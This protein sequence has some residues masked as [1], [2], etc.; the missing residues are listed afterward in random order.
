MKKIIKKEKGVTMVALVITVIILLILTNM[1]IYNATDSAQIKSLTS[2]YND[3]ELL[4]EKV[5]EYYNEYGKI[6]ANIEY[7]NIDHLGGILNA[8]EKET[9]S[10][11][12][13]IDLQTLQGL[14]LNYGNEYEEVKNRDM[15]TQI[16]TLLMK[17]H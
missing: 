7:T 1:L 9:D 14:T 3:I 12:Y 8:Q 5:S 15:S 13:V 17:K 2:L 10:K 11:F 4:R 16:Y 6:P